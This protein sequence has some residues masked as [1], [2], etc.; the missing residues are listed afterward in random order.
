[1]HLVA[2]L[3]GKDDNFN[4]L[5]IFW[6]YFNKCMKINTGDNKDIYYAYLLTDDMLSQ[7]KIACILQDK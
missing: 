4:F 2:Q 6:E 3:T 1:M 5:K 7:P